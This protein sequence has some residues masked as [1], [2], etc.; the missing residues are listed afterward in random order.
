MLKHRLTFGTL[1][2]ALLLGSLYADQALGRVSLGGVTLPAGL[3]ILLLAAGLVAAAARELAA[4]FRAKSLPGDA[5]MLALAGLAGLIA[6]WLPGDAVAVASVAGVAAVAGAVLLVA[7]ARQCLPTQRCDG[8]LAAGGAASLAFIYL[9]LLPGFFLLIR[10]GHSAW[11][12]AGVILII[13]ACDIGAYF[14]GRTLGRHKLIAWLSPGK[15][16]EGLGGGV[17]LAAAAALGLAAMSNAT[18]PTTYPLA[19]AAAGG[20]LLGLVGQLGDLVASALKRDAGI[21]DAGRSIPG[22]GGVL[23]VVDSP[24][25]AAPVAYALLILLA[26]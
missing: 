10:Q 7:I 1:M 20:A 3:V 12:V 11:A 8:A 19:L 24:L 6:M 15:T 14:T 25:L 22:F 17:A 26:R 13:K 18:G 4:I 23:D 21:K 2:I 16:W 5:L 9:G